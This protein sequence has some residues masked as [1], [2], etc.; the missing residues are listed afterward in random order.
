MPDRVTTVMGEISPETL[1]KTL[2][3]EH[4]L[5]DASMWANE[6]PQ[7]IGEREKFGR[8]VGM[9]NRGHIVYHNFF[10]P[11]NLVQMDVGVA[12]EEALKFRLA[13]GSTICDVSNIGIG[14]DPEALYRISVET[15][16]ERRHGQRSIRGELVEGRGQGHEH[17]GAETGDHRRV[18]GWCRAEKNPGRASSGRSGFP[19]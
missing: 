7:E 16:L 15:G 14:R 4:L 10:Y 1:G 11:D 13:G 9:G 12:V 8:P 18:Q 5:W 2:P 3:H 17:R 19:T 6:A